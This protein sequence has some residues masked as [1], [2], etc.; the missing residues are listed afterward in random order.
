[1][2]RVRLSYVRTFELASLVAAANMFVRHVN[3]RIHTYAGS[4]GLP[5]VGTLWRSSCGG[6]LTDIAF[7]CTSAPAMSLSVSTSIEAS[8]SNRP[9]GVRR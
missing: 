8:S 4:R 9:R 5:I 6:L 1:M 3:I 2:F 7:Y